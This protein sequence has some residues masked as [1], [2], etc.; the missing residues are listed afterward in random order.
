MRR[1]PDFLRVATML[2]AMVG[3]LLLSTEGGVKHRTAR[4]KMPGR[5]RTGTGFLKGSTWR[6]GKEPA[7]RSPFL[8]RT[9][10]GLPPD[11]I[12]SRKTA[13]SGPCSELA[14][15]HRPI[16]AGTTRGASGQIPQHTWY[17]LLRG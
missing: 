15:A 17:W 16:G 13:S 14:V 8:N 10:L 3:M 9:C 6:T 1:T 7:P 12:D 2:S 5:A 4:Q 11:N